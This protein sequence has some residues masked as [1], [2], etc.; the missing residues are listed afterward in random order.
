VKRLV[1]IRSA[2]ADASTSCRFGIGGITSEERKRRP[3][4]GRK[5]KEPHHT[6]EKKAIMKCV[7]VCLCSS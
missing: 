2:S 6:G 5:R 1:C 4:P 3:G 7:A